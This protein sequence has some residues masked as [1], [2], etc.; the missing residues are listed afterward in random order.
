M[1]Q[2]PVFNVSE[3]FAKYC[4]GRHKAHGDSSAE[5]LRDNYLIPLLEKGPLTVDLTGS[6]TCASFLEETFGGIVRQLGVAPG[7]DI[8]GRLTILG[9]EDKQREVWGFI[10]EQRARDGVDITDAEKTDL[11]LV[12]TVEA[13][14]QIEATWRASHVGSRAPKPT[15]RL[16]LDDALEELRRLKANDDGC[17]NCPDLRGVIDILEQIKREEEDSQCSSSE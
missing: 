11:R 14:T 8:A 2:Q 10:H 3:S 1:S 5:E 6:F 13:E 16:T 9:P 4:G 15:I 12:A 7:E 17:P